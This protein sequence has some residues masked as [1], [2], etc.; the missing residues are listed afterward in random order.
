[1]RAGLSLPTGAAFNFEQVLNVFYQIC[2][3]VQ[4]LHNQEP[5][6]IHR[7]LK[8]RNFKNFYEYRRSK[9]EQK[10][11]KIN[12]QNN[13]LSHEFNNFLGSKFN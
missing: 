13:K 5:P 12:F 3:S 11:P 7:D 10:Y 6:I 8:V 2:K 1:L 4:Y 9:N